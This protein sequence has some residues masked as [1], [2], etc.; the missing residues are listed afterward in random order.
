M[1]SPEK[2]RF[3]QNLDKRSLSTQKLHGRNDVLQ[4][5]TTKLKKVSKS[6]SKET[7]HDEEDSDDP[8]SN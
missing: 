5:V 7:L 2:K 8:Y 1:T 3:L 6:K 4:G